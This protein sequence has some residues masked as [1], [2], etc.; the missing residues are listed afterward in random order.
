MNV[1]DYP[2]SIRHLSEEEG[3]G[4][5][6]EFPDLPGCMSDGET[7]EEAVHNG[8]D[9]AQ[10]WMQ[11]AKKLGREIPKPSNIQRMS[12]R[13]VQRVPKSLHAQLVMRAKQEGVSL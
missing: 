4:F 3:G 7:V 1:L 10:C 6:I 12:G 13:W 2:F 11:A 5:L 8:M 9:A